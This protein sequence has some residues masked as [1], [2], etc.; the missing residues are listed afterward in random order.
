M[1]KLGFVCTQAAAGWRVSED[2]VFDVD[3]EAQMG[4]RDPAVTMQN[5]G[6]Y[7]EMP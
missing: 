5:T 2:S 7:L 4:M 3:R 6:F 1:E